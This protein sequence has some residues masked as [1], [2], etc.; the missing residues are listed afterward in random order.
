M[1]KPYQVGARVSILGCNPFVVTA[2][3]PVGNTWEYEAKW[4]GTSFMRY[5]KCDRYWHSMI[6]KLEG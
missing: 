6:N 1:K 3:I 5:W 2:V 4:G